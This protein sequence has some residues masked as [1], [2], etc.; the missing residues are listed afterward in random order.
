MSHAFP[1]E[2]LLRLRQHKEDAEARALAALE[3]QRQQLEATLGRV[4]QQLQQ[5]TDDR[6][7][8]AGGLQSAM[9]QQ[10]SYARLALLRDAE[11]ELEKQQKLL[12]A[13]ISEQQGLFLAARR[14]RKMLAELKQRQLLAWKTA[15]QKKEQQQLE[16][17]FLS[18]WKR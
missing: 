16:D 4:R 18:R 1:L 12:A 13:S 5:W 6:S 9:Q 2:A 17:L 7:R 10:S 14:D 15:E 11:G 3:A 8:E